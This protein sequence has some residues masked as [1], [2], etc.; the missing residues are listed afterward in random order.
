ME[1][2]FISADKWSCPDTESAC[3]S[4]RKLGIFP[5]VQ[6]AF[7]CSIKGKSFNVLYDPNKFKN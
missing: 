6:I 3:E 5:Q 7:P 1:N 4:L 2:Q